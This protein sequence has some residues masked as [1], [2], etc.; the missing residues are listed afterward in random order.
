MRFARH[1]RF[2]WPSR[3]LL[4]ILPFWAWVVFW[5]LR[6]ELRWEHVAM[7]AVL[8]TFAY[9]TV[10]TRN[11][12]VGLLPLALTAMLYDAMKLGRDLG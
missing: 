2:L 6:H 1:V 11:L 12:Y 4:P 9:A 3:P 10:W 8:S 5:G 7:A